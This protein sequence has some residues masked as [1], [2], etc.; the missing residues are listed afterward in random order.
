MQEKLFRKSL[1]IS[2]FVYKQNLKVSVWNFKKINGPNVFYKV[3]VKN[4]TYGSCIGGTNFAKKRFRLFQ[5]FQ[6]EN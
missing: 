4:W 5:C 2:C 1:V 6:T 3:F